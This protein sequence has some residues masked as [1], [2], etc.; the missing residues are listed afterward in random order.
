MSKAIVGLLFLG[1]NY[2]VYAHLATNEVIPERVPFEQFADEIEGWS[3]L[4]RGV[5]QAS[6]LRQL[7]AWVGQ[8]ASPR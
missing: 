3:C 4:E 6:V 1:L 2:Y 8:D 7:V 5:M